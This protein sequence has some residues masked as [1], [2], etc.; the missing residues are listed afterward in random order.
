[1]GKRPGTAESVPPGFRNHTDRGV[2]GLRRVLHSVID[3]VYNWNNLRSASQHVVANHGAGGIDQVSTEHWKARE[4]EYLVQLRKALMDDTYRSKPARRAYVPKP[5]SKKK[6]GLGI[7]IV[8]DRVCQQAVQNILMPVFEEYF[9]DSSHG[10][11]PERSTRTAARQVEDI[12]R[13][14]YH[15]VVN[16]DILGFFDNVDHEILMRLVRKVIKDRRVLGLIR[17][18]LKA[19][20]MEEGK[21]RYLTSGTPQG[22]VIS[23]LLS[24]V[25]LTVLDNALD[26]RGIKFVRYADD[27][28]L[29]CRNKHEAAE[30]LDYVRRVL[31]RLKLELNEGKTLMSSFKEGFDFLGFR[32]GLRGRGV[33]TKSLRSFYR[34]VREITRRQQGDKPVEAVIWKLNPLLRGWGNYH[35]EGRN[36]GLFT[37]LDKWVRNR[38]RAYIHKYWRT[39]HR[40]SAKPDKSAFDRMSLFSMRKILRPARSQLMLFQVP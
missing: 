2:V 17:G 20:V 26:D 28:L 29:M 35:C 14:G 21:V 3:K 36:V 1:M 19:G 40:M 13:L 10:F 11:R 30:A 4:E 38:L 22:G 15:V 34:K 12:R 24:N 39:H 37:C 6:R 23:P 32:F 5:G 31:K 8:C 16:L 27:V 33:G 25:Y 18:W 9:H 7:P